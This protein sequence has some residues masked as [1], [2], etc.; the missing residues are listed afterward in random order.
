MRSGILAAF[1]CLAPLAAGAEWLAFK[2]GTTREIAGP[3]KIKGKQL[4]F[5]SK[6]GTLQ[7]VRL[8]EV[9]LAASEQLSRNATAD[10]GLIELKSNPTEAYDWKT[11][12]SGVDIVP[13]GN[14]DAI[15]VEWELEKGDHIGTHPGASCVPSRLV[16]VTSGTDWW[17]QTG[18]K[19][20]KFRP[21]GLEWAD[22]ERLKALVPKGLVCIQ[23]DPRAK[24]PDAAGRRVGYARL[25]DGRDIGL[26]LLKTRAARLSA[27]AFSQRASYQAAVSQ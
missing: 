6:G 5:S 4:L 14:G 19:V 16:G 18:T 1:L 23:P 10:R 3:W 24:S 20:E 22:A 25:P 26:E 7:A 13:I 15:A 27:E 11:V 9:D 17:L 8:E 2:D 12:G 21:V